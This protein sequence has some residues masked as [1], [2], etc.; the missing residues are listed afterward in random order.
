MSNLFDSNEFKVRFETPLVDKS[1]LVNVR[2][3]FPIAQ[4][5]TVISNAN[6]LKPV[7]CYM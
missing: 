4:T 2:F 1:I 6:F 3:R 5:C 7:M